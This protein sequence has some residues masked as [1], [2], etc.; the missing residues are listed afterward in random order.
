MVE[1][2]NETGVVVAGVSL[3]ELFEAQVVRCPGAVAVVCGDERVSFGELDE[4]A[5]RLAGVL[6]G[7]GVGPESVVAVVLE[8][9]VDLVVALL[10]VWKAGAAYVPVDPSYPEERVAFMLGDAHPVCVVTASGVEDVAGAVG[11]GGVA[12]AGGVG[13]RVCSG[14]AA[15]VMYTSGSTGVPKGV[16]VS[17]AGIVNR[18]LWMQERFG[19]GVD[20]VVLQKTSVS[21]DV[22]VWELFSSLVSGGRLVLARPGGQGDPGYLSELIRAEGVTTVHFVPS[23]LDVFV[24]GGDPGAWGSLRRVVCSGEALSGVSAER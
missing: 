9:S 22:S 1:G 7:R 10:G 20:D 12:G 23:M 17:H 5:S 11:V 14:G 2:W 15:Y 19:L 8:R 24:E 21:F 4:R 16:V 3:V 6:V 18:L 13:G